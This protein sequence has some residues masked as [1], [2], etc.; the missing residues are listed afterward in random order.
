MITGR[1]SMLRVSMVPTLAELHVCHECEMPP[2]ELASCFSIQKIR[3]RK[4]PMARWT[5]DVTVFLFFFFKREAASW[6]PFFSFFLSAKLLHGILFFFFFFF[7]SAKL[8][9]GILWFFLYFKFVTC[10]QLYP[11]TV[12]EARKYLRARR[13]IRLYTSYPVAAFRKTPETL[14]SHCR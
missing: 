12:S 4:Y 1:S 11:I 8:L 5:D 7:L 10:Y 6:N 2:C 3:R 9:Y 13:A 14:L